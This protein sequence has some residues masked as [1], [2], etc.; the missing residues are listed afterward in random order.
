MKKFRVNDIV[1]FKDDLKTHIGA[2]LILAAHTP[3][4]I[5]KM[6]AHAIA[7]L[8]PNGKLHSVRCIPERMY[9]GTEMGKILYGE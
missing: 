6:N 9:F 3:V 7:I 8:L 2:K 5:A 4:K 1:C